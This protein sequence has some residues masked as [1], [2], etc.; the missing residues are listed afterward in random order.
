M[1]ISSGAMWSEPVKQE[2]LAHHPAPCCS[3]TPSARRKRSA[4]AYRCRAG[5]SAAK[6][7]AFTLGPDVKVL[8]EDGDQVTPG[9]D[10]IGILALGGRNPLGY[11]KDDEKSDRTFKEIDGVRYSIPGDFAQVRRRRVDPPARPRLRLHQLGRRED[12][13]RGGGGGAQ[14]ARR[15]ARRRRGRHSASDLRR[16]DRG[17]GRGRRDGGADA[18]PRR[19]DRARQGSPGHVQGAAARAGRRPPSAGRPTARSTTSAIEPSRWTSSGRPRRHCP[20]TQPQCTQPTP[21][22]PIPGDVRL[23]RMFIAPADATIGEASGVPSSRPIL[24]VT[25]W[26]P[27][28]PEPTCPSSCPPSSCSR[29]ARCGCISCGPIPIFAALAENSRVLLERGRRLGLHP[30][31]VEGASSDE[32][33]ALGIPTTYYGAVQLH[34]HGDRARRAHEPGSRRRHPA[35]PARR[36]PARRRRRRPGRSPPAKLHGHPRAFSIDVEHVPA[37]F[38]YGGNVDAAHRRAVVDHLLEP[39]AVP[40]TTARPRTSTSLE[41]ESGSAAAS[42]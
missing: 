39:A 29:A 41:A 5:G 27:G 40:A 2:L 9:S 26:R 37:K 12:L 18:P 36:V 22:P 32:D 23:S 17:R 19:T 20:S 6:T 15:R 25:W 31:V 13:P 3:S 16:A 28:G 30:L 4:W 14:D 21:A 34:R 24:S 8:T 35:A 10:E 1:V 33:P 42:S 38:K 7:A 11:Y